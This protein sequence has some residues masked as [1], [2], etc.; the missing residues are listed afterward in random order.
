VHPWAPWDEEPDPS[1]LRVFLKSIRV[2]YR[3]EMRYHA[4]NTENLV[5]MQVIT[6]FS[7]VDEKFEYSTRYGRDNSFCLLSP[8]TINPKRPLRNG[9]RATTL[10]EHLRLVEKWIGECEKHHHDTC[11]LL[12]LQKSLPS[13]GLKNLKVIDVRTK[14]SVEC[15]IA[16]ISFA[17]LSYVWGDNQNEN[18]YFSS[19][20]NPQT[21]ISNEDG[22]P[23]PSSVPRIIDEAI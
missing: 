23:L 13:I 5:A 22:R 9:F 1:K 3:E 7:P 12:Q 19:Q 14:H 2:D 6:R 20:L 17:A 15:E 21:A 4:N 11:K 16:N 8:E 10:R 18:L